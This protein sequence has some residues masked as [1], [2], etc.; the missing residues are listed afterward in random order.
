[1]YETAGAAVARAILVTAGLLDVATF[2]IGG[3]VSR[4]WALLEPSVRCTLTAEPPV[5]GR[6]IRVLP[7]HLGG[8]AVAVGAASR[9]RAE[10]IP[11]TRA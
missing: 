10:L 2:V 9:A 3:G 8:D 1:M 6:R 11:V 5:S 7:A 4:A